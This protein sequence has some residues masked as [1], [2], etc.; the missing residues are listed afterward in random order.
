MRRKWLRSLA[1]IASSLLVLALGFVGFTFFYHVAW[2]GKTEKVTFKSGDLTI[3]GLLVKPDGIAPQPAVVILHGSGRA[4]GPHDHPG[5][6]VHVNAFVRKGLSV[7]VYDKRGTGAGY[8]DFVQDALAAV[9][10]LRGREDI[11][12]SSSSRADLLRRVWM[13]DKKENS[14]RGTITNVAPQPF[15]TE[16]GQSGQI[17]NIG[18]SIQIKGELQGNEDLTIDGLIEGKIDLRDHNLTIGPNGK[19]RA[20]LFA[21]TIIIAGEVSGNAHAAERV[22]ICP[23]GRLVGDIV[24]PRI[25][26]ADGAHFKGSVDMERGAAE[27]KKTGVRAEEIRR[28]P[29][30]K[31]DAQFKNQRA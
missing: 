19:I 21:K 4:A 11:D 16:A 13:S 17:V 25:T 7:L 24:S 28:I 6:R 22:E 9:Q 3:A 29:E 14:A 8:D 27:A 30:T 10:F 31:D 5:Y 12:R 18:A 15:G 23:S 2:G 26:I 20:D 1:V